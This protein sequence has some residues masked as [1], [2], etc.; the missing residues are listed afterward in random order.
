[1]VKK[2]PAPKAEQPP[3]ASS[4]IR[5]STPEQSHGPTSRST[6]RC[7]MW[8]LMSFILL[9]PGREESE[10]KSERVRAAWQAKRDTAAD[11][12]LTKRTPGW[13]RLD[14][15][16]GKLTLIPER[17]KIVRQVFQW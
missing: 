14:A 6:E 17:A 15:K 12:P 7:H 9:L 11:T 8:I 3:K 5:W 10:T 2:T 13:V 4:Y 1:M 16:S